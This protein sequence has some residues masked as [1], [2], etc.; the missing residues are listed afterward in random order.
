LKDV[1]QV[2]RFLEQTTLVEHDLVF[3]DGVVFTGPRNY[4][5]LSGP[6]LKNV[7]RQQV[8]WPSG[9]RDR[10]FGAHELAFI[11]CEQE[12]RPGQYSSSNV[13][14]AGAKV[15]CTLNVLAQVRHERGWNWPKWFRISS[16]NGRVCTTFALKSKMFRQVDSELAE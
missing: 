8:D 6:G 13:V 14:S 15:R 9:T 12:L 1:A 3:Q 16:G 5:I 10:K 11:H 2:D 4:S 7:D